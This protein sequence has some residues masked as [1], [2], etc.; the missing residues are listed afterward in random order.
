MSVVWA[1][2]PCSRFT[3]SWRISIVAAL[4]ETWLVTSLPWICWFVTF[5][6]PD[7]VVIAPL[8]SRVQDGEHDVARDRRRPRCPAAHRR[9]SRRIPRRWR[10]GWRS[11]SAAEAEAALAHPQVHGRSADDLGCRWRTLAP[12]G[13]SLRCWYRPSCLH[14]PGSL[15]RRRAPP[16]SPLA[17]S[18]PWWASRRSPGA[19]VPPT[20][21]TMS[22]RCCPRPH[23]TRRRSRRVLEPAVP[24][25][26]WRP[27]R[28][29][30][31]RHDDSD[32]DGDLPRSLNT[33]GLL[34]RRPDTRRDRQ[35][36]SVD[37]APL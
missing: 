2:L 25:S 19:H 21:A 8:K 3:W 32:N 33:W 27:G 6:Y 26:R 35:A 10:P 20:R 34:G 24:L 16:R 23:S 4:L 12:A 18:R 31:P 30:R 1:S 17:D 11:S 5:P 36:G 9:G 14:R 29:H 13:V 28:H 37:P 22:S 7:S 15:H